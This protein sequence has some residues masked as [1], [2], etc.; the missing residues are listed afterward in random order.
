MLLFIAP[1]VLLFIAP[2]SSPSI[3]SLLAPSSTTVSVAWVPPVYSNGQLISYRLSLYPLDNKDHVISSDV[4]PEK[5]A[6]IFG[7]L[8]G[9]SRYE[10]RV[11]AV[12]GEGEGPAAVMTVKTPA[13]ST[14]KLIKK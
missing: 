8:S 1:S 6:W 5:T 10:V 4:T 14:C 12:N 2:S 7:H 3:T 9:N 13:S 11:S